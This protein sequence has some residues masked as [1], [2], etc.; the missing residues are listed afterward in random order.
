LR[1]GTI[2]TRELLPAVRLGDDY[3]E[4]VRVSNRFEL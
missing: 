1:A 2:I 3:S 4:L